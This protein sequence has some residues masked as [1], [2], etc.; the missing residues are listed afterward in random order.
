MV[1]H[2]IQ[3]FGKLTLMA[4]ILLFMP[5]VLTAIAIIVKKY[6]HHPV[7]KWVSY[8][9]I[10]IAFLRIVLFFNPVAW[11]TY[12]K[13]LPAELIDWRQHDAIIA[14]T[15][16]YLKPIKDLKYLAVGSSQTTVI[17]KQYAL[18]HPDLSIFSFAG[19]SPLD[20][21]TY[22]N[23]IIRR[24]PEYLLLYLSEFD[25]AREPELASSKWSPFS[26]R[27]IAEL[28][29]IIDTTGYFKKENKQI[30]YDAFFGKYFP[31]FKYSFV[32]KNLTN[33]LMNK[34]K[35]LN[36]TPPAQV[37]MNIALNNQLKYLNDLSEKYIDFNMYYL[38]KSIQIF[39]QHNIKV[40]IVEG[41]Y[42]PLA[43]QKNNLELNKKV[44]NLLMNLAGTNPNNIFLSRDEV[45][46]FKIE[47][48]RDG[49]HVKPE[50]G[51]HFAEV[52]IKQLN[53]KESKL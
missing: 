19:L 7:I 25:I 44:K 23:E 51:L 21:Y 3:F 45:P 1:S 52:L 13:I 46:N 49:Y 39:N 8:L 24:K 38:N 4:W 42:H 37:D 6:L 12:N 31:E 5:L 20:L 29:S 33:I 22:H 34:N 27:D 30:L 47:D 40:I 2:L 50:P 36:I 48:Y 11:A 16:K 10:A 43:Y 15:G 17:Y 32:F 41:Q 14:E 35:L 53:L 28:R 26:L 9:V 18:M